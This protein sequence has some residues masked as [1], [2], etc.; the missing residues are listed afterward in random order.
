MRNLLERVY[1]SKIRKM[2]EQDT[3]HHMTFSEFEK[4]C[5]DFN[6]NDEQISSF[7]KS[8]HNVGICYHFHNHPELKSVIFLKPEI[9]AEKLTNSLGVQSIKKSDMAQKALLDSILPKYEE[10]TLK[11]NELDNA[12]DRRASFWM[13]SILGFLVVEFA[14]LGRMVWWEFNWDI[15]EPI[16]YFVTLATV[17]GGYTFF[18]FTN[19][20]YEYEELRN[21]IKNRAL[22]KK[23]L[24]E[25][26]NW[27]EWNELHTQ[28]TDLKRSL[29][30]D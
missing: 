5:K 16:S 11:K 14:I 10:L 6:L 9:I 3:R 2:I 23:Y 28:V 13:K 29:K 24:A 25:G 18:V 22:R 8:L 17:M 26:F 27:K 21:K 20:E 15:V 12:A 7:I 1:F 4:W 30:L 19:K